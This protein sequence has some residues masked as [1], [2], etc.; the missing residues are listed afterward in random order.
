M[1]R[2]VVLLHTLPDGSS[3]FDW[4][5]EVP[6]RPG[7]ITF[8]CDKAPSRAPEFAAELLPDHRAVYLEYEGPVSGNRGKVERVAAG[9]W[10]DGDLHAAT[11]SI[12]CDWGRG[13]VEYRGVPAA[14]GTL[15]F[16]TDSVGGES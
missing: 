3:H 12:V 7:L 8:R 4:M 13:S 16:H 1:P 14:K 5:I 15:T 6:G 10:S 11:P 9:V 2:T